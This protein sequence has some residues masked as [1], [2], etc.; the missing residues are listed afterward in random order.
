MHEY[1]II[2]SLVDSV[3]AAVRSRPEAAVHG[4]HVAIGELAGVDCALLTTA[5]EVFAKPRR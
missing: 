4:V 2:Q 1:S 5:Y 3:T